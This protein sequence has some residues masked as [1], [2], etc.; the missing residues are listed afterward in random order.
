MPQSAVP[1]AIQVVQSASLPALVQ[2]EIERLI[3]Q[4]ELAI[5]AHLNESELASRFGT[6]RG[7]IREA[8]R[9][10]EVKRL[11]PYHVPDRGSNIARFA[12]KRQMMIVEKRHGVA[13]EDAGTIQFFI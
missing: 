7:P 1:T 10:L 9:A 5:G 12:F 3:L 2:V 8:L 6:S 13:F 4:G 11:S